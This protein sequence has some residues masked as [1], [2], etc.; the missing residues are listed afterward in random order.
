MITK[1]SIIES[2]NHSHLNYEIAKHI[3]ANEYESYCIIYENNTVAMHALDEMKL[4][5]DPQEHDRLLMLPDWETLP[6]DHIN[7]HKNII[8]Q[9]MQTLYRLTQTKNPI[10]VLS[11]V[12]FS[13][14]YAP[15]SFILKES[16]ICHVGQKM[17][18]ENFR[19]HMLAKG[20]H[21]TR[22]VNDIGQF[23][24]RGSILDLVLTDKKTSSYR[25]ELFDDEVDSIRQLDLST[26]R[27][28]KLQESIHIQPNQE[29]IINRET[30][31]I[32][33]KNIHLCP[34]H[35]QEK[36]VKLLENTEHLQGRD[37][38][39]AFLHES[40]DTIY[41]YLPSNCL[42][43]Q[44]ENLSTSQQK[45]SEHVNESYQRQIDH[46]R[47]IAHPNSF[48]N[49]ESSQSSVYHLSYTTKSTTKS[50]RYLP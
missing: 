1:Y 8:A 24:I 38:Y 34:T 36:L 35:L 12:A 29:F 44:P 13:Y 43:I 6:Y 42:V 50:K 41:D 5:L 15:R 25:I 22:E 39:L 19:S 32:I 3:Q 26:N 20:Y 9:R 4:F 16:F 18:I 30:K 31:E 11:S 17:T 7:A 37:Y 23:S 45:I 21:E 2:I 14:K 40:L 33:K 46:H 48:I 47:P 28:Q 10:L 49:R 27:S